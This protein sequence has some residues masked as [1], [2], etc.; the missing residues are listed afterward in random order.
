[1]MT[2]SRLIGDPLRLAQVLGNLLSN[3]IKFTAQGEIVLSIDVEQQSAEE[4]NLKFEVRDTGIGMSQE[5][6]AKLFLPFTQADG[7][8]TRKY[9]GTGLGLSICKRVVELMGGK[10][11][12]TSEAGEG[13]TF[14]FTCPL[15][16]GQ[17]ALSPSTERMATLEGTRVLVADDC[18]TV[19]HGL[20]RILRGFGMEVATVASGEAALECL[21]GAHPREPFSLVL[22]DWQMP[23]ISGIEA[24]KKIRS[25]GETTSTC[26]VMVTAFGREAIR[27][28]AEAAGVRRFLIK[29]FSPSRILTTLLE[30]LGPGEEALAPA[31]EPSSVELSLKG[32]L[33]LVVDDN[34]INLEISNEL[35]QSAGIE[36]EMAYDGRQAVERVLNGGVT[37]DAV[38][39]DVQMPEM[40]GLEATRVIRRDERF[41]DL[42][43]LGLTAHVMAEERQR[44]LDCGMN[45]HVA[46]PI[47]PEAMFATMSRWIGKRGKAGR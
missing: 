41:R 31:T 7:S 3:A 47:D 27:K 15:G 46:K 36:V 6:L 11:W 14:A 9:G 18:A 24:V 28:E 2:P 34:E 37:Y 38:L 16:R 12:G 19:R 40:D 21:R 25:S 13:S 10:I 8:T 23:G 29:P 42:P 22:M 30:L 20:S 32:A 45:D 26:V 35:L 43:I 33:V 44:C 1:M 5:Q 4:I 17:E 39:M